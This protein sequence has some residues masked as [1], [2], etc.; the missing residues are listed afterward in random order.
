MIARSA[1]PISSFLEQIWGTH[2]YERNYIDNE[3]G[4]IVLD[5]GYS[6]KLA[7]MRRVQKVSIGAMSDYVNGEGVSL[8][9]VVSEENI[10]DICTKGLDHR[11]HWNAV[12]SLCMG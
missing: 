3:A 12:R 8:L 11:A 7:H 1:A 5:T 6:R 9:R 2:V 10:S 4:E